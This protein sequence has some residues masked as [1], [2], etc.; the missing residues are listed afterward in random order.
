MHQASHTVLTGTMKADD[1]KPGHQQAMSN[2]AGLHAT[3]PMP[4]STKNGHLGMWVQLH[5]AVAWDE[6]KSGKSGMIIMFNS[7]LSL[8]QVLLA[9]LIKLNLF[10]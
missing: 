1:T 10:D 2:A 9:E 8:L 3:H 4:S 6:W 7:P 5:S